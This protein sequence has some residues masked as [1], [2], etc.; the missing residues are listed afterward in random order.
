[1]SK[2]LLPME[3]E[4]AMSPMPFLKTLTEEHIKTV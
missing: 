4:T 2:T 3:L 1:M